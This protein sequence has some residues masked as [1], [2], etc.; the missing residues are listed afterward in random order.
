MP[1]KPGIGYNIRASSAQ[2]LML[3]LASLESSSWYK[4]NI[5]VNGVAFEDGGYRNSKKTDDDKPPKNLG[6]QLPAVKYMDEAGIKAE[7]AKLQ[8]PQTI[9]N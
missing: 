4:A 2:K 9:S 8:T 6:G 7:Q 5:L 1:K 3:K